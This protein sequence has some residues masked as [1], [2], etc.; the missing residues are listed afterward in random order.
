LENNYR[1]DFLNPESLA[2]L[3][4]LGLIS[5]I[6]GDYMQIYMRYNGAIRQKVASGYSSAMKVMVG[7]RVSS[8]FYMLL[9]AFS[10][11]NA[12]SAAYLMKYFS[13][14]CALCALP[15]ALLVRRAFFTKRARGKFSKLCELRFELG[16]A[17]LSFTAIIFNLLGL[18]IPFIAAAKFPEYRLTLVQSS[19]LFN[20]VYTFITVFC[21][22]S[23]FANL[24]DSKDYNYHSFCYSISLGRIFGCLMA[25]VLIFLLI[26]IT[27][28][29]NL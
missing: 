27:L 6:F 29:L 18:T 2:L 10:I 26:I 7:M 1:G 21:I 14:T 16:P 24:V 17:L 8:V 19:V 3:S 13:W 9:I 4:M 28:C 15:I 22:E 11:E 5:Y 12:L 20:V 25:A 23:K